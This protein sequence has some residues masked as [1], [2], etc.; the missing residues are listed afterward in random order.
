MADAV[1]SARAAAAS[2][3]VGV[4]QRHR[5]CLSAYVPLRCCARMHVTSCDTSTSQAIRVG[6]LR[7]THASRFIFLS[8]TVNTSI[9]RVA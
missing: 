3:A 5:V 1:D 2:A 4:W 6:R 9:K 7:Q 8:L